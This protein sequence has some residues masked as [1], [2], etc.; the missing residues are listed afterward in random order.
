VYNS[1]DDVDKLANSLQSEGPSY[2]KDQKVK[3]E[4]TDQNSKTE[5]E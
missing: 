2:I 1:K 3:S 5:T 4:M